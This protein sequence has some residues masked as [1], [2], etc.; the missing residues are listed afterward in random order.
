MKKYIIGKNDANQ[1]LDKFISKAVP[2]LPKSLMYKYIR[3]KRIKLCGKKASISDRLSENDVVELYINDEFFEAIPN[4]SFDFLKA[5]KKLDIVY[6][7][8][9]VM[10]LNKS[11]GLLCHSAEG[12]YGD[13]LINRVKRYLYEKGEYNPADEHGFAP[14]LA[15]RIDRN[16]CGIVMAAKN[17]TSLRILNEKIKKRE[18]SKYYLCLVHGKFEKSA[19]TV[20]GFLE[21]DSDKNLVKIFDSPKNGR[22][23]IKTRYRVLAEKNSVSLLEIEL[24]TG[25][26]HQI[27]AHMAYLGHPLLGDGK[28]GKNAADRKKGFVHQ[29]L[30][31]YRLK[32]D[33][34][35]DG[36]DLEYLRGREFSINN[37]WFVDL[38]NSCSGI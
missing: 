7:D 1:R 29:A 30:C 25:R 4:D 10:L 37:I 8:D 31:S 26:T 18:I 6:E 15:N 28:Y 2:S 9:N 35:T 19:D 16:T 12:E 13:T 17:A 34:T 21:K 3:T 14:A 23:S 5:G 22:L 24:L 38:F 36:E 11:E 32:F 20:E 33:F 27:R